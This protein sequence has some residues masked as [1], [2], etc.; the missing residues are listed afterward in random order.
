M[1]MSFLPAELDALQ[2]RGSIAV[3]PGSLGALHEKRK[4]TL[5]QYF[6]PAWLSEF[7]WRTLSPAFPE[8]RRYSLLDNSIGSAG[9]F[10]YAHPD[11]FH[12]FG[13]DADAEII[14]KVV[15]ALDKSEYK[16]DILHAY[17]EGVELDRFSAAL[18]NPPFSIPLSSPFLK[19]YQGITH[20]GK[21]GPDTSAV[22]HEY[23]LAQA[24]SHCDVV[25]AVVPQSTKDVIA[26]NEELNAR[27]RAVFELPSGTFKDENVQIVKTD[28]LIFGR[29]LMGAASAAPEA[30]RVKRMAINED[31]ISPA[32]FQLN[33]RAVGDISMNRHPIKIIGIDQSEPVITTPVTGNNTVLLKRSGRQ[34]KLEF[35][36]G[37][38]EGRV[39]NALYRTRLFSDHQ[40]KYPAKTVY[41]GQFKL[42]IDVISMHHN[43]FGALDSVCAD[44]KQAGGAPVV[45][46]QLKSDLKRIIRENNRM[47]VQYGRTV[48]RKGVPLFNATAKRMALINRTQKNAAVS[49]NEKVLV[50]RTEAGFMVETKRGEFTCDHDAFFS[51]FEPEESAMNDGYWED[52]YPPIEKSFP[53]EI[54]SLKAKV[55]QLG[56]EQWLTWDYQ[57]EDL[58]ELAFKPTGGICGWQMALGK[59]R[60]AIALALILPGRSLIVLKSRLVPEMVNE[61]KGLGITDYCIVES[62]KDAI[63]LRKINI[64]SYERLKRP[65]YPA[66]PK[67]TF[68]NFLRKKVKNVL[69]DEGGLLANN[70]SQQTKAIWQLGAK[71]KYILDGTPCPNYPREMLSLASWAV[72][73]ER[74]YQPY[75]MQN[76][77]IESRLFNGAEFQPKGRDEF[78]RRYVSIEW[79]TNEWLDSGHGAKREVPKIN[80]AFLLDYRGWVAPMIKRR[81]QQEPAV[82]KYVTFPV[83]ELRAPN[84]IE[85]EFGHLLLYVKTVEEFATWYRTYA[86]DRGEEGKSLNLTMILA[87]LEACFKAANV[88]SLVTGFGKGF[89]G[90]TTKELY[91]LDLI[92]AEV[93]QGLRPIVFARNPAVLHRLASELDKRNITNLVFSGEE[94]ITKR[95]NKL[96][97]RIRQGSDQV[98]LASFGVTQDGLNLPQFNSFI[99]YNRS[100]DARVEFQSIY[101][102]IRPQ[103]KSQVSGSFLHMKGSIDCYQAQLINWKTCASEAGLDYGEQPEN[104]AFVHFDAFVYNFINSLPELKEKLD[105]MKRLAA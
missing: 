21:H 84:E 96:N 12:L 31:S 14:D 99:F 35:Y 90:L 36:D 28:L 82:R 41:G 46:V 95:I 23:A 100:F 60:L 5:S 65:F 22:S 20:Y 40:H 93:K 33:A 6:T 13:F 8:D 89:Q 58:C 39:K 79:A 74:A 72:G 30:I 76:G 45:T 53:F 94:T 44:I 32:M 59:S 10:R 69:C 11:K 64:I 83:P 104:E 16:F 2:S 54:A 85:W 26:Q 34:I 42:N 73:Q 55:A 63:S 87:R 62:R 61:L 68:A 15:A 88:P 25:A 57:V 24:L 27:L 78:N 1:L 48:Y 56:I 102:L 7:I 52:I 75:S 91:C 105:S 19:P 17:M 43:P 92:E 38:T 80:P 3:K 98:M 70:H 49:M 101:R 29:K 9:M 97:E 51:L 103:Q 4:E 18:I 66:V 86:K 47:L 81:L 67:F 71:R 50:Q 77:F 37:A